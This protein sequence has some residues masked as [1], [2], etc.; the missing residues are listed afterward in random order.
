MN[1]SVDVRVAENGRMV[2]PRVVRDALGIRGETKVVLTIE[3][4]EVRV[5]PV[6]HG[7]RRVQDLYRQHAR[8]PSSVDDFLEER[9]READREDGT[10]G[11]TSTREK[12]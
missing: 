10:T 8:T 5:A 3:G 11:S 9:R 1:L 6:R 4:E 12:D 2:L 7:A